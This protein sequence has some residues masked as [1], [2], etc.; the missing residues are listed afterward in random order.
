M[1]RGAAERGA[2][3][4]ETMTTK[5]IEKLLRLALDSAASEHEADTAASMLIRHLRAS[6]MTYE[7]FIVHLG[8]PAPKTKRAPVKPD[9]VMPFG[10]YKGESIGWL[11]ANNPNY[12]WWV[13]DNCDKA[14]P[15]LRSAIESILGI[16]RTA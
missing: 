10:K 5:R 11:L 12:L 8:A 2:A 9:V 1:G 4:E 13:L 16:E 7:D 14:P 3:Q 6:R 15:S